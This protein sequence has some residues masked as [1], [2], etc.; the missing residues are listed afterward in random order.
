[1]AVLLL[2]RQ[3]HAQHQPSTQ[4]ASPEQHKQARTAAEQRT[5]RAFYNL[6]AAKEPRCESARNYFTKHSSLHCRVYSG[7]LLGVP[8]FLGYLTGVAPVL[9]TATAVR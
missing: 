1:M 7:L 2:L 3:R 5:S 6:G 4:Q 8:G 9:E